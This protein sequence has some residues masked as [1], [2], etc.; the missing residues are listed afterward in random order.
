MA[1]TSL[2]MLYH[3]IHSSVDVAAWHTVLWVLSHVTQKTDD[4]PWHTQ[5]CGCCIMAYTVLWMLYQCIHSYVDV[6]AT[7]SQKQMGIMA[8]TILWMLYHA[9]HR[10]VCV[11]S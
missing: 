10:S 6:A 3:G 1:Y 5:F 4:V 8:Y 11:A 9:I 7:A 2:W